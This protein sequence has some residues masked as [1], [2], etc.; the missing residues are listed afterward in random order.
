MKN[1]LCVISILGFALSSMAGNW[2]SEGT[3]GI[4]TVADDAVTTIDLGSDWVYRAGI[5]NTHTS[6]VLY[7]TVNISS[8]AFTNNIALGAV[9]SIAPETT[10]TFANEH[11]KSWKIHKVL[12]KS[13]SGDI[14]SYRGMH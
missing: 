10:F 2:V 11:D 12:L 14:T 4:D 6:S 13:S 8:T 5:Y 9:V 3:G 1:I 7:A